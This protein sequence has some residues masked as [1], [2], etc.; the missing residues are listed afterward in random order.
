MPEF[1]CILTFASRF[2]WVLVDDRDNGVSWVRDNGAED[3]SD[4]TSSEGNHQLFRLNSF[5][6]LL[7]MDITRGVNTDY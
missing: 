3:T 1:E 6:I 7:V 4:V 5:F 2:A